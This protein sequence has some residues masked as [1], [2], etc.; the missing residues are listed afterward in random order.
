MR[1]TVLWLVCVCLPLAAGCSKDDESPNGPAAPHPDF[2]VNAATG[3]DA[4]PG[5]SAEPFKTIGHALAAAGAGKMIAVAPGTYDTTNGEA[6][7]IVLQTHQSLVGDI[8]SKG[9]GTDSTIIWGHGNAPQTN[10]WYATIVGAEGASVVGFLIGSDY[11]DT[12][13]GVN[14]SDAAV[15]VTDNTFASSY[16]GVLLT[17]SGASVIRNN[18]FDTSSYGVYVLGCPDGPVIEDN[19]FQGMAIP[20]NIVGQATRATVR[21]NTIMGNGA[22]GINVQHGS[23]TITGNT[24]DRPT[25]YTY[26]ALHCGFPTATPKLRNN[27]FVCGLAVL[28]DAGRPD[29]GTAA[30]HGGND[31]AAVTGAVV[32]HAGSD[33]ISAIGNTWPHSPPTLNADIVITGSGWVRWG[34]GAGEIFP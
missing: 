12:Q 23:P 27:M 29:L 11:L 25:G 33:T 10:S 7:P 13:A 34:T 15:T 17:G 20:M 3:S 2:Y 8:A 4:F 30:D 21:A 26:G 24:F 19:V 28:I 9:A 16:A 6:F 31:F 1:S 14:V 22:V 32:K 5:T 18:V